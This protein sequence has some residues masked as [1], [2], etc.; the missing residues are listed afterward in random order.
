M[1]KIVKYL[2]GLVM[3]VFLLVVA[4]Y[5]ALFGLKSKK[6]LDFSVLHFKTVDKQTGA[7]VFSTRIVCFRHRNHDICQVREGK[8]KDIVSAYFPYHK[9]QLNTFLF[10]KSEEIPAVADPYFKIMFINNDYY[11]TTED[12]D[13]NDIYANSGQEIT[14]KLQPRDLDDNTS[15]EDE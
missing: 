13:M 15:I 4:D 1:N 5:F 11:K 7:P 8:K 12:F 9:T 14:I 6:V 3:V 2:A 10:T